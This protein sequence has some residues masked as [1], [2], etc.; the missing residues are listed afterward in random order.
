MVLLSSFLASDE[1][2]NDGDD[3]EEEEEVTTT[4]VVDDDDR[5]LVITDGDTGI[6]SIILPI[7]GTAWGT[8]GGGTTFELAFGRCII[9][10]EL[11]RKEFFWGRVIEIRVRQFFS[12][13][14]I[15]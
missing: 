7:T 15:P 2:N 4:V 11:M 1:D 5:T 12:H 6:R 8:G 14:K 9:A 3:K 10:T 13:P